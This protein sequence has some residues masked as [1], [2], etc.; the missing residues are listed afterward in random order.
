M[1]ILWPGKLGANFLCLSCVAEKAWLL[2]A[3][4]DKILNLIL[5]HKYYSGFTQ[6]MTISTRTQYEG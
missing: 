5:S 3:S 2:V 4:K 6:N 1:D